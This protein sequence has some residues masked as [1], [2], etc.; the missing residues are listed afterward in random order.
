MHKHASATFSIIA[1]VLTV[2]SFGTSNAADSLNPTDLLEQIRTKGPDHVFN[3]ILTN[4]KWTAFLKNIETGK[5]PW[6]ELAVAIY[7]A[8]DGGPAEELSLASGIAL[9][10]APKD[11]LT[12]VTPRLGIEGI[13]DYSELT[14]SYVGALT[15]KQMLAEIDARIKAVSKL[16]GPDIAS[17]RDQCLKL[18][19]D[20]RREILSP[21]PVSGGVQL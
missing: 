18:L 14:A 13:C 2:V 1:V 17:L 3:V 9:L 19:S 21:K 5:K 6:L 7:P 11:V 20:A 12:I 16:E 10:H 15:S 8:T 4:N